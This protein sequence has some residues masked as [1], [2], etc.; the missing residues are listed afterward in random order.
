VDGKGIAAVPFAA[1]AGAAVAVAA[2]AAV[3]GAAVAGAAVAGAGACVAGAAVAAGAQ[4]ASSILATITIL[5]RT[6]IIRF[7]TLSSTILSLGCKNTELGKTALDFCC[8]H[9]LSLYKSKYVNLII[10]HKLGLLLIR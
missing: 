9:L 7:I 10:Q 6:N 1:H 8:E 4:P 3:A 5:T 2:G